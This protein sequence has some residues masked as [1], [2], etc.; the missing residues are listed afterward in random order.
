MYPV[1]G[2]CQPVVKILY[3]ITLKVKLYMYLVD[4][5]VLDDK[6]NAFQFARSLLETIF[7]VYCDFCRIA[8]NSMEGN[9]I[10]VETGVKIS[11]IC[12]AQLVY[13]S[14]NN[15]NKFNSPYLVAFE[16]KTILV[17]SVTTVY[18]NEME[19][20]LLYSYA[21][22]CPSNTQFPVLLESRLAC[23]HV[24]V[25]VNQLQERGIGNQTLQ[26]IVTQSFTKST[27][28]L[29]ICIDIYND[30]LSSASFLY[31]DIL[32]NVVIAVIGVRCFYKV[33]CN[34]VL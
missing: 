17:F 1:D 16:K 7:S 18:H 20:R 11:P 26:N 2:K 3:G 32:L 4:G 8:V 34:I 25:N 28:Q 19:S 9:R 10:S 22:G 13:D 23:P 12:S 24:V 30:I 29:A 6:D 21:S 5:H 33:S 27:G 31:A 14:L 15:L